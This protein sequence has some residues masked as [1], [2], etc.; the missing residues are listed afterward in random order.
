[1]NTEV[2]HG[3]RKTIRVMSGLRVRGICVCVCVSA[4]VYVLLMCVCVCFM[5]ECVLLMWLCVS[6]VSPVNIA[7]DQNYSQ[8][9]MYTSYGIANPPSYAANGNT[10][11]EYSPGINCIHTQPGNLAGWWE[12]D[13]GIDY[14]IHKFKVWGRNNR[15]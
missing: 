10:S 15:K 11:G 4:P 13:L 12:V 3:T 6:C 5:C 1:M 8:S 9:S 14:T 2:L 7:R